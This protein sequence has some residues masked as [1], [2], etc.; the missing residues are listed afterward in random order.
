VQAVKMEQKIKKKIIRP[1]LLLFLSSFFCMI[2]FSAYGQN[3][4]MRDPT[5]PLEQNISDAAGI[6]IDGIIIGK[7]RRIVT[8]DGKQLT[9]GN[10]IRGATIVDIQPNAVKFKDDNGE[11]VVEMPYSSFKNLSQQQTRPKNETVAK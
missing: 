6:K 7:N 1:I 5:V 8:I 2:I 9:V 11:F 10:K 3:G 4:Q